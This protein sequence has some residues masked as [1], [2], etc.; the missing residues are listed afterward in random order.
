M[1]V[2]AR[3][4]TSSRR[5]LGGADAIDSS[6]IRAI[7]A[8]A[9][10]FDTSDRPVLGLLGSSARERRG[11]APWFGIDT[12]APTRWA[13]SAGRTEI[14]RFLPGTWSRERRSVS[15]ETPKTHGENASRTIPVRN[16]WLR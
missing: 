16:Y 6:S 7:A 13:I 10:A 4:A 12:A 5:C 2:S 15:D 9:R 1:E 8:C 14:I 11:E 3:K